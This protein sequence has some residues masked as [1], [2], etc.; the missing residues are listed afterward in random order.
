[1]IIHSSYGGVLLSSPILV[2]ATVALSSTV[3]VVV[4][5]AFALKRWK[6]KQSR[7]ELV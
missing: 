1:L 2:Y 7:C 4:T 3:L 6:T 5:I